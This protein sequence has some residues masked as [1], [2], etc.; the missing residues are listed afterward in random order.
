MDY[1]A[2]TVVTWEIL[3]KFA[4]H[5]PKTLVYMN[6]PIWFWPLVFTGV[7]ALVVIAVAVVIR[8]VRDR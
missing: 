1:D 7:F 8:T 3:N 6:M 4:Q 5:W 2:S